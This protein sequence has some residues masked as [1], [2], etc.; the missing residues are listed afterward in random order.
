MDHQYGIPEHIDELFPQAWKNAPRSSQMPGFNDSRWR[1]VH[2][3]IA[4]LR[5]QVR[6]LQLENKAIMKEL[7]RLQS[8]L[9]EK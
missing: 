9:G 6:Q 8:R 7:E 4:Q 3:F 1:I 5:D 2:A